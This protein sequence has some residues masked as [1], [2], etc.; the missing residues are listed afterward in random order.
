MGGFVGKN[1]GMISSSYVSKTNLINY[2]TNEELN[3][4][5]GF[6]GENSGEINYSFVKADE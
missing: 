1:T 2:S 5:A 4:T 3:K 6:V